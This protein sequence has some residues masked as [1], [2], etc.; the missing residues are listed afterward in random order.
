[1]PSQIRARRLAALA[2]LTIL[3][4]AASVP[5]L[6]AEPATT[7]RV[8]PASVRVAGPTVIAGWKDGPVSV[9][10]ADQ[11]ALIATLPLPAGRWV[12]WAK[13]YVA[14]AYSRDPITFAGV[15][16]TLRPSQR[17]AVVS[18]ATARVGSGGSPWPARQPLALSA[19]ASFGDAGGTLSL[20]CAASHEQ[21]G[22]PVS[23]H[24]IK[25]MA[26]RVGTLTSVR[27]ADGATTTLGSGSPKAVVG[28]SGGVVTMPHGTTKTI[29]RV[30]LAAGAWWVRTSFTFNGN[31]RGY[32]N[33]KLV[34]GTSLGD[35]ATIETGQGGP[36]VTVMD[37]AAWSS[38]GRWAKVV[39]KG[40]SHAPDPEDPTN[41]VRD[42]HL[43]AVKLG[44][45]VIQGP[46]GGSS[47]YGSGWPRGKFRT[48]AERYL[49][50]QQWSTLVSVPV[51]AGR[52]M[53]LAKA[54]VAAD[55]PVTCQLTA[56]S[57]FDR[58]AL[59]DWGDSTLPFAVV[60]R[61]TGDGA[62]RLRCRASS[63]GAHVRGIR[64]MAF[65]LGSLQN[66]PL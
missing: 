43:S 31:Y 28:S 29:G 52:W 14:K 2:A 6:G 53:F 5:A 17:V 15:R 36:L 19:A 25:I 7:V 64:V 63:S 46:R 12:A 54:E 20:R 21:P 45:L 55:A 38:S 1:M 48:A 39:C 24:W 56:G 35:S 33:C 65:K 8:S 16:C 50:E 4:A 34:L 59:G 58:T 26:M 60:H 37:A 23:A 9:P 18:S 47:T 49:P 41:E 13:L 3:G 32:A 22:G 61:F 62:A 40:G 57:D 10:A 42:V 11:P 27:L 44:T 30:W 51:E 66:K